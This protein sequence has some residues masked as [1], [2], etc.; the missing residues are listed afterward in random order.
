MVIF[1]CRKN[2]RN[3]HPIQVW[4][5][6]LILYFSAVMAQTTSYESVKLP[7]TNGMYKPWYNIGISMSDHSITGDDVDAVHT[8]RASS[9]TRLCP[10]TVKV[11]YSSSGRSF[12]DAMAWDLKDGDVTRRNGEKEW[13]YVGI[14]S[15]NLLQFAKWKMTHRN[16]GF[17]HWK[18]WCSTVFCMFTRG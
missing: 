14:P 5:Y 11:M 1:S 15:G 2:K 16:S 4:G 13:V 6:R 17:I 7:I 10:R 18:W 9:A 8:L 12:G 3:K